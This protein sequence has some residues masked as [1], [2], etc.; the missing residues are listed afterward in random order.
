MTDRVCSCVDECSGDPYSGW[1][2][3]LPT[4]ATSNSVQCATTWPVTVRC[5][6][7][8]G[9]EGAH[10]QGHATPNSA[11]VEFFRK[12]IEDAR[13]ECEMYGPNPTAVAAYDF[14]LTHEVFRA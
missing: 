4:H 13:H 3:Q 5:E 1:C 2:K 7:E 11:A 12:L 14:L 9:H 6:L 8:R 10:K